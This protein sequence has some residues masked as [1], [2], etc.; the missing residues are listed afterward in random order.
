MLCFKHGNNYKVYVQNTGETSS[1]DPFSHR[2]NM[3]ARLKILCKRPKNCFLVIISFLREKKKSAEILF[4]EMSF[5]V[6]V[7]KD[8]NKIKNQ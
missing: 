7:W 4:F 3:V 8:H 2:E 5:Y 1:Q 6:R